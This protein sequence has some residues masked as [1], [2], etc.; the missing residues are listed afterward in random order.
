MDLR[1]Y[2]MVLVCPTENLLK[3][4]LMLLQLHLVVADFPTRPVGHVSPFSFFANSFP[5]T[6]YG[7]SRKREDAT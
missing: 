5:W 2:V 1:L 7:Y 4:S 3:G 6:L